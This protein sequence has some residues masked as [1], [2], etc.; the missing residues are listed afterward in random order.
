MVFN[1]LHFVLFFVVVYAAYRLLPHRLQNW[2]LLASSYYFYAA[3]DWRF[4]GLLWA[5]TIVDFWCARGIAATAS[6]PRRRVW[7]LVSL[8]FA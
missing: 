1:S 2:L 5:Q 6:G 4:L 7:L 3:W 8:S